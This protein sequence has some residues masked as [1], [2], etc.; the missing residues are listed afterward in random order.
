[1]LCNRGRG[2]ITYWGAQTEK[3][4]FLL[5]LI[6]ASLFLHS[7]SFQVEMKKK[8]DG[9][10]LYEEK[11]CNRTMTKNNRMPIR[12]FWLLWYDCLPKAV[13]NYCKKDKKHGYRFCF[14][15]IINKRDL[16]SLLTQIYWIGLPAL[17]INFCSKCSNYFV[18]YQFIVAKIFC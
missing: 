12:S 8:S 5:V 14:S 6:E 15:V 9:K 18:R 7:Y 17:Q 13:Q 1:M 16:W 2:R 10:N 11:C 4:H 3:I